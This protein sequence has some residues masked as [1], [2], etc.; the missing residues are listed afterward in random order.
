MKGVPICF[1][2]T[3]FKVLNLGNTHWNMK[4][5]WNMKFIIAA[6]V[7]IVAG[8]S[9]SAQR[10]AVT[11]NVFEDVV[12][13]P[14]IGIDIVVADQQSVSLDASAAPYKLSQNM[15]NKSMT[16]RVGYKYW[17]NQTFYS[18]YA[19][20]DLIASSYDFGLRNYKS[21]YEYVGLGVGY[22][23]SL[24]IGKRLNFVPC[25]GLGLA[26]GKSY[27]GHDHMVKP[28]Q[29]VEAVAT[30]TVKPVVT[31]LGITIQYVLN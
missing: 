2:G 29:G 31:R 8:T 14:N 1:V 16:L 19:G 22:G 24:I 11:S 5:S 17:F 9:A 26:V 13:T 25:V 27:D 6:I 23:Y 10:I 7:M 15:Y 4:M 12:L 20:V 28:G 18:H 30:T 3:S 21:K